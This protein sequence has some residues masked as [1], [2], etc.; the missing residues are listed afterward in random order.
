MR[1]WY[2]E[3]KEFSAIANE[4]QNKLNP[5]LFP[6]IPK[7]PTMLSTESLEF[8]CQ[9]ILDETEEL[10][11]ATTD[12]DQ[13][14][15][16]L[17]II[18]YILDTGAK[19][20]LDIEFGTDRQ[21]DTI[22]AFITDLGPM[23]LN[24]NQA[25]KRLSTATSIP[26]VTHELSFICAMCFTYADTSGFNLNPLFDIVQKA[27]MAKF[28]DGVVLLDEDIVSPRYGKVLKPIGWEKP[29]SKIKEEIDSQKVIIDFGEVDPDEWL[30]E[31]KA[32][33]GNS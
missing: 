21:R 6:L 4:A 12:Y 9:M 20:C 18:Y 19:H 15:A 29:D 16:F 30:K 33:H 24:I 7:S 25:V 2:E 14:D 32:K 17:D 5:E 22:P 27:N 28:K 1:T 8:I 3:V 23:V 26:Q 31:Q 10:K 13:A 11:E